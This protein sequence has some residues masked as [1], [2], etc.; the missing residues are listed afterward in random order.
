MHFSTSALNP[1]SILDF[2]KLD[3]NQ[4]PRDWHGKQ[5]REANFV[6]CKKLSEI[7]FLCS[8]AF[9]LRFP[10]G[11]VQTLPN[12]F[13]WISLKAV[14]R[15]SINGRKSMGFFS[16]CRVLIFCHW[17]L[18]RTLRCISPS[19]K[20]HRTQGGILLTMSHFTEKIYNYFEF[21]EVFGTSITHTCYKEVAVCYRQEEALEDDAL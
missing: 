21:P 17:R 9:R 10:V 12:L 20:L 15:I 19:P 18:C 14:L 11:T 6:T 13:L 7:I 5:S 4:S 1:G 3:K 16:V 2:R 8:S